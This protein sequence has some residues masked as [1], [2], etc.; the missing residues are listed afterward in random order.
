MGRRDLKDLRSGASPSALVPIPQTNNQER[1]AT[2]PLDKHHRRPAVEAFTG[3]SRSSIYALMA[4]G[5]FPL[6]VRL[7]GKA[8]AWPESAL[9]A[10]LASR[11][12]AERKS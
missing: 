10:W 1:A 3:L 7:T 8:V 6:P 2:E 12:V 4:Q 9:K 5:E 11:P